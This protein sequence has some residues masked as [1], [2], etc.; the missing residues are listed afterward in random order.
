MTAVQ[1]GPDPRWGM[2]APL[3]TSS[4][5]TLPSGLK[6]TLT[7]SR[8][9]TLTDPANPFSLSS[10][11]DTIIDNGRASTSNYDATARRFT[12]NSAG[13]RAT[14]VD[15]DAL[16]RVTRSQLGTLAPLSYAYVDGELRTLTRGTQ[17]PRTTTLS[18]NAARLQTGVTDPLNRVVGTAYDGADRV[19]TKTLRTAASPI[20]RTMRT[21]TWRAS[22]HPDAAR[23]RSATARW[24]SKRSSIPRT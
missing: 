21:A 8:V 9:A 10:L 11:N 20:L 2:V 17:A 12:N 3:A 18:Y 24:I 16:G 1:F 23:T 19:V 15:I 22:L 13:G 6:R 4:T 7:M 5:V 14:R